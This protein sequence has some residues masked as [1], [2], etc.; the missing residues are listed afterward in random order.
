MIQPL[1]W[2]IGKVKIENTG[3]GISSTQDMG[4]GAAQNIPA[5]MT[6]LLC[7]IQ[8]KTPLLPHFD[9]SKIEVHFTFAV[10]RKHCLT[11]KSQLLFLNWG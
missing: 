2:G 8:T 10:T 4:G 7:L 9:T 11:C 1:R 5:V 6:G 3:K